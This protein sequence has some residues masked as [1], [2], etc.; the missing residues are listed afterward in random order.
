MNEEWKL[1]EIECI[2]DNLMCMFFEKWLYKIEK[3]SFYIKN[4]PQ[5]K[6]IL[7]KLLREYS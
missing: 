6:K 2:L 3:V 5:K 7:H 1:Y 4:R